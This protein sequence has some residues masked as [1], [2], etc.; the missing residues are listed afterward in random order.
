MIDRMFGRKNQ[1]A[2]KREVKGMWMSGLKN[3]KGTQG[4]IF[5]PCMCSGVQALRW[6]LL[7]FGQIL[8]LFCYLLFSTKTDHH[9]D[10]INKNQTKIKS[11]GFSH[12]SCDYSNNTIH[13]GCE[14][15]GS[16]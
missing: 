3:L 4:S 7:V 13:D 8:F 12:I 16:F 11:S 5:L 1:T 6:S 2:M 14:K 10:D 9:A 15:L